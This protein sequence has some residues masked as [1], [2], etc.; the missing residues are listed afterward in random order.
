[1]SN[2]HRLHLPGE[3]IQLPLRVDSRRNRVGLE[4]RSRFPL[5]FICSFPSRFYWGQKGESGELRLA[6]KS[7]L[8]ARQAM[9]T[10]GMK[11]L[12]A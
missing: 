5:F 4:I 2:W 1:M 7:K 6:L 3:S 9:K 11:L 12:K 10:L 8:K